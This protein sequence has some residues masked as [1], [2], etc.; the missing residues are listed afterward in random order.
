MP[1]VG[2]ART[3]AAPDNPVLKTEGRVTLIDGLPA[4]AV[5]ARGQGDLLRRAPTPDRSGGGQH[6][7]LSPV[8][9]SG[10]AS[11]LT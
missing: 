9:A 3:G 2:K 10:T 1:A 5:L 6:A 7:F 11:R 4:A 8:P